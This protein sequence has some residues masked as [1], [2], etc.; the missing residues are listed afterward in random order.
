MKKIFQPK[1][2]REFIAIVKDMVSSRANFIQIKTNEHERFVE[3][4]KNKLPY[5]PLSKEDEDNVNNILSKG[6]DNLSD[7]D[8]NTLMSLCYDIYSWDIHIGLYNLFDGIYKYVSSTGEEVDE[9]VNDVFAEIDKSSDEREQLE[10]LITMLENEIKQSIVIIKDFNLFSKEPAVIRALLNLE[11]AFTMNDVTII[12]VG[13][14]LSTLNYFSP[15]LTVIEMPYPD[16]EVIRQELDRA[17]SNFQ[18]V[19][20]IPVSYDDSTVHILKGLSLAEINRAIHHSLMNYQSIN[21]DV[22]N[23]YKKQQI[24]KTKLLEV[25]DPEPPEKLGGMKNLK[26][27]IQ[28]R[29]NAFLN[30][31][32]PLKGILLI[33]PPGVGKSLSAKVVASIFGVNLIKFD[34]SSMKS[35]L[36]GESESNL[37][38]ALKQIESISPCVVWIDEIEKMIGG[39]KSS[40]QSDS[41]TT[42][43][44]FGYLLSWMQEHDK[45][46]YIVAT[47]N[48][49]KDLFEISQGAIIRRF[50]DIFYM[51]FPSEEERKEIILSKLKELNLTDNKNYNVDTIVK[52]TDHFTGAEIEKLIRSSLFE[53]IDNALQYI[54][55]IYKQ[56]EELFV[57]LKQWAINKCRIANSQT[58]VSKKTTKNNDTIKKIKTNKKFKK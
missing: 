9:E 48:D 1:T 50:D 47:A 7:T 30:G 44:M 17:T 55:P 49:Y 13:D 21:N 58:E 56:N 24:M 45:P 33:G 31:Y 5:I 35:S 28:A 52:K 11:E 2:E 36:V 20:G 51:D 23:E 19:N 25:Y 37:R 8:K 57:E 10:Q 18:E 14:D 15:Y 46:I 4:M 34:L 42:A 53:G 39:V 22:I 38:L 12:F 41:G 54:K 26:E 27:Y 40:A 16:E 32:P 29:K 43:S 6:I 3:I